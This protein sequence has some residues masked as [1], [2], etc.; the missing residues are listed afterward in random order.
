MFLKGQLSV[1]YKWLHWIIPF[2]HFVEAGSHIVLCNNNHDN[3]YY[4]LTV[5]MH[6]TVFVAKPRQSIILAA[7][8]VPI[9]VCSISVSLFLER[10][11]L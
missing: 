6:V 11:N 7:Y 2:E 4:R 8:D 3:G 9:K 10:S 1:E 5:T